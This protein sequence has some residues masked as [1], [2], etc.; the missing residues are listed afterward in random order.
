MNPENSDSDR[1]TPGLERGDGARLWPTAV[2]LALFAGAMWFA[3]LGWDHEYY[4]VDGVAQ[5]PYRTWQV[6]GCGLAIATATVVAFFRV[7]RTAATFVLAGA[8]AG[9]FAVPWAVWASSDDS[10]MWLVGL[11]LLI[12]GGGV[13]LALLLA[14]TNTVVGSRSRWLPDRRRAKDELGAS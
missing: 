1:T 5:G 12:I 4:D 9:G 3:W 7:P 14:V 13:G 8:A 6:V 11:F 2:A 10:G